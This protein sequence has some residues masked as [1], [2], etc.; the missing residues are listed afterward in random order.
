MPRMM[1]VPYANSLVETKLD[2]SRRKRSM[3]T[4][5]FFKKVARN[6]ESPSVMSPTSFKE[7]LLDPWNSNYASKLSQNLKSHNLGTTFL[8]APINQATNLK[9]KTNFSKVHDYLRSKNDS[10]IKALVGDEEDEKSVLKK[11]TSQIKIEYMSKLFS[12]N[13]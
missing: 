2:F 12:K 1:G 11:S 13:T 8:V 6:V 10:Y 5:K 4:A 3:D 7:V 9:L